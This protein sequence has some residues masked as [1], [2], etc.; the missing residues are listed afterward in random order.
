MQQAGYVIITF[1]PPGIHNFVNNKIR[2]DRGVKQIAVL[3]QQVSL[4]DLIFL[5]KRFNIFLIK[6]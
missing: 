5:A 1:R 4:L 6:L 3:Q 2:I